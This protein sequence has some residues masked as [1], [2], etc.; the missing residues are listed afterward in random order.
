MHLAY[1]D[2]S[3]LFIEAQKVSA[4]SHGL[5]RSLADARDRRVTDLHY[6]LDLNRLMALLQWLEHPVRAML[7]GSITASNA[8]LW[9]HAEGAGFEVTVVERGFAGREKQVDTSLV[10]RLCR[11]AYRDARPGLD[12]ITLVAGDGDYLP[13]VQQLVA[14]GFDVTLAYWAH[15]SRELREAASRFQPLDP[16]VEDLSL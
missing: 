11:D 14:D 12:R 8:A 3:N 16:F 7:F 15:A 6:R 10:A 1:V 5:A 13:A 9:H 2:C 4:V